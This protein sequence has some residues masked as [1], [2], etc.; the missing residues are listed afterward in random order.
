M[1]KRLW[2]ILTQAYPAWLRWRYGM[3]IGKNCRISWSAHLDKSINPKGIWIGDNVW[4]LRDAMVLSHDYSR[5]IIADTHIGNDC[6]IGI[7]SIVL[8]G[9]EIGAQSVVGAGAVVT[10]SVPSNVIVAGN[11]ARIIK[12]GIS[13]RAGRIIKAEE[14]V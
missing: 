13:V 7:R 8:P 6:I 14:Y 2:K 12:E 11:P 1:R 10:K 5:G 3:H 9:V 4:I